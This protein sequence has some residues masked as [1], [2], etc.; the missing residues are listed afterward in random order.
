LSLS[1]FYLFQVVLP[2]P[3][4]ASPTNERAA[5]NGSQIL[6][7]PHPHH[8]HHLHNHHS[9]AAGCGGGGIGGGL[10]LEWQA[11]V[12]RSS[13]ITTFRQSAFIITTLHWPFSTAFAQYLLAALM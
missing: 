4:A 2:L 9:A 7:R 10:C 5:T 1:D 6:P 12:F 3:A 11:A 8:P 13:F